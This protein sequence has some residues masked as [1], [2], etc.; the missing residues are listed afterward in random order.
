[1]TIQEQLS[2]NAIDDDHLS[3]FKTIGVDYVTM[4]PPPPDLKDGQDRTDFWNK[5]CDRVE[6]HGMKLNNVGMT[7]GTRL[8][9]PCPTR[10]RKSRHGA[11]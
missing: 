8:P 10:I 6:S 5:M 9:L 1:M 7:V 2:W 11:R 3:F 4:N